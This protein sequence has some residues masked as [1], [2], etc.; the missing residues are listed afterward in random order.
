VSKIINV[1]LLDNCKCNNYLTRI[2]GTDRATKKTA[3]INVLILEAKKRKI[4]PS[5]HLQLSRPSVSISL[6]VSLIR[7]DLEFVREL[8]ACIYLVPSIFF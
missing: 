3:F 6:S 4:I 1:V 8:A 5:I 2:N 7:Q